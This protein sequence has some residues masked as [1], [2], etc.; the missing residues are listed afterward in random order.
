[1]TLFAA[2]QLACLWR[3]INQLTLIMCLCIRSINRQTSQNE[4]ER[5]GEKRAH[6]FDQ[7]FKYTIYSFHSIREI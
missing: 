4:R 7:L 1:M 3:Q 2:T 5:E 6:T